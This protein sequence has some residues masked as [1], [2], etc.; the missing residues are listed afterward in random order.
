MARSSLSNYDNSFLKTQNS[1]LGHHNTKIY[2]SIQ[3]KLVKPSASSSRYRMNSTG[4]N[5]TLPTLNAVKESNAFSRKNENILA[6]VQNRVS[7]T[8]NTQRSLGQSVNLGRNSIDSSNEMQV[9]GDSRMYKSIDA[10]E[11]SPKIDVKNKSMYGTISVNEMA[12]A[13][14]KMYK[15]DGIKGYEI[16]SEMRF[17]FPNKVHSIQTGKLNRFLDQL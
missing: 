6:S 3:N 2:Q 13:G 8:R 5:D 10:G 7:K 17:N 11:G 9:K 15:Q 4:M 12:L 1:P 14:M 16:K